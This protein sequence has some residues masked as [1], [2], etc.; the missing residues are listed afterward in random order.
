MSLHFKIPR[1]APVLALASLLAAALSLRAEEP[2]YLDFV[3]ALRARGMPDL[4]L[5]YL[6]KLQEK[7]PPGLAATLPL[8]MAKTR[9]ELAALKAD[10]ASRAAEQN[11]ARAELERFIKEHP[12]YPL[13]ADA[14]VEI[15]RIAALQGL[16]QLSSARRQEDRAVQQAGL[17][18][19]RLQFEAAGKQLEAAMTR[20]DAVL[21]GTQTAAEKEALAQARL[22]AELEQGINLL[23]LAQTYTEDNETAK[24][25]EFLKLAI[26]SLTMLSKRQDKN[27][28]CWQA[29]VWLGRCQQE[30]D[31]PRS[32]RRIY[33]QVIGERG[34]YAATARRLAR[35]FRLQTLAGDPD[36]KPDARR[37]GA[38]VRAAAEEWLTLYPNY[39]NTPEGSGVRFEL[40]QAY[41]KLAAAAPKGSPQ[42]RSLYDQAKKLFQALEQSDNDYWLQ[43]HNYKLGIIR[44]VSEER[45]RGDIRKLK[46]FEE[47]YLRAE[48]EVALFNEEIKKLKGEALDKKRDLHY[49]RVIQALERG[50]Q[51]ADQTAPADELHDARYLLTYA[52]LTMGDYAHAAETGEYLARQAPQSPR[53]PAAGAYALRSLSLQIARK[54]EA[55]TAAEELAQD[56][57]HLRQFAQYVEQTWPGDPTADYARHTLAL[58]LARDKK[59]PEAI[60]ALE[61]ISPGYAEATRAFYLLAGLALQ[62]QKDGLT[63]AQGKRPYQERAL[64]ALN[65]VPEPGPLADAETIHDYIGAQQMLADLYYRA[66]QYDRMEALSDALQKRLEKLDDRTQAEFR[67]RIRILGLYARLGKAETEYHAGQYA[68][69]LATLDPFVKLVKEPAQGDAF[70]AIKDKDSRVVRVLLG[71]ALRASVQD[72]KSDQ[73]REILELAQTAFPENSLEMLVELVQQLRDQIVQLR[74]QGDAARAQLDKITTSFS[75]FLEVLGK[76]EEKDPKPNLLLFLAQSYSSLDR[77]DLAADLAAKIAEPKPAAGNKEP[78]AKQLQIYYFAQILQARELRLNGQFDEAQKALER[79][80]QAPWGKHNL[81]VRKERIFLLEDQG[82]YSLPQKH[83]AIP[84]WDRLMQS[85]KP[86]LSDPKIK[87]Q[88]F[89]AY[90]HLTFCLFKNADKLSDPQRKAQ[91]TR[92]AAN[93]IVKLQAQQDPAT[94]P[95]K[96]RFEELLQKEP[97]LKQEYDVLKNK[98]P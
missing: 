52:Y 66:R 97:L 15:A 62:A 57:D 23:H 93:Y 42:A 26:D 10:P 92:V 78:D 68:Q 85:L 16:A 51:L 35:Y 50:L 72:N 71:L 18:R 37:P 86:R 89:D 45:T 96:K 39:L 25:A 40:A 75:A 80:Q 11:E 38:E 84:E 65:K 6:Q 46:D 81:E 61:R 8:E 79:I 73:A 20:I 49:Q 14:S 41:L 77:H 63:P 94:E 30:N 64:A 43:A 19:A 5:E 82:K 88:Y 17:I 28:I 98:G 3:R 76:Q 32:A 87:E 21:A 47:C 31:D 48:Y 67:T 59:Y 83:G 54:E 44:I 13:A 74:Q 53:A 69:V 24:R 36:T 22:Q 9:L 34:E 12:Q 7:P 29:L 70:S 90:Y 1:L 2:P 60:D 33:T 58:L 91:Y 56:R 4:A 27:P 55:G 95:C